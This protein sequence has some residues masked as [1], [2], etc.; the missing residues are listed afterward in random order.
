[1]TSSALVRFARELRRAGLTVG[2]SAAA[3]FTAATEAVGLASRHDTYHALCSLVVSGPGQIPVFDEVFERFFG[4]RGVPRVGVAIVERPGSSSVGLG[5]QADGEGEADLEEPAHM[6]ASA[7]ERL[8]HRDFA[9]LS[10]SESDQ[11]RRLI[12]RMMWRP[13]DVR[14]RRW[15]GAP[16]GERPDLRRTVRRA[17]GP[18]G[19]IIRL[20]LT[21]RRL[22]RR[23]VIMIADVSGS[24]ERYA[25]MLLYFAHAARSRLGRLEAF[26]FSTRLTRITRQLARRDAT[27]ALVEVSGTVED[28]SGGTRIGAA[29]HT[30]N[31]DWSRRVSR[32]GP[33]ALLVSDGWDRGEPDLLRREM[34]RFARSVHR[35]VWLNPL[36]G[37]PGFAPE[38]RGMQAVLPYIDDFLPAANLADLAALVNLLESI[39]PRRRTLHR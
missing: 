25:E 34:A 8:A 24:M 16:R 17:I 14:S 31:A 39:S 12:A 21:E 6:G 11:L 3:D 33:V 32:G 15:R 35:V 27:Q 28:W 2:P 26:V 9:E 19:E 5:L 10:P 1:M 37:R 29:L 38:T 18:E 7:M 30:F 23:P 20:A 13:T 4:G 22:R 36:A